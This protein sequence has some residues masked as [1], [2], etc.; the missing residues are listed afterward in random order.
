[1]HSLFTIGLTLV[2]KIGFPKEINIKHY[3]MKTKLILTALVGAL[4]FG[5]SQQSKLTQTEA[6]EIAKE[7]YVYGFPMVM[8]YKTLYAYVLDKNSPE[9]K[10]EFNE[11]SCDARLFTPENKA[12]VTPNSDT[13]YCMFWCDIRTEPVVFSVP[14]IESERYYS[15]QLIDMY[16]HNFA[17]IGSL[18]SG[19]SAGKYLIAPNSWKGEK[20]EGITNIIPCETGLFFTVVRTQLMNAGDIDKVKEIQGEYTI[21]T[22]SDYLDEE[23]KGSKQ[24][25]NFPDWVEGDQFTA[26]AFNFL[27]VVLKH[28]D[29]VEEEKTLM[30]KFA[31]IGLRTKEGFDINK[32]DQETQDSIQAGVKEGFAEMEEFIKKYAADPLISAKIFGTREFLVQSAQGNYNLENMHIPRAVAAH[33]G[34]YGNSGFEATYPTYLA[35]AEAQ[36]LNASENS[37]SITFNTDELPPVKAFWSITMYDGKT[38]LLINN[39]IDRYLVNSSMI[40]DFV[41]GDDGSLT[42]Y[43]QKESPGKELEA[44][45]LPAPDG[46]FYCVMRLYGPE[47]SALSGEW[48]NPPIVKNNK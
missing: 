37:Y 43:V 9:Y 45:W 29:P 15:F 13:P 6:K 46:P 39:P 8:N 40:D 21:Q 30:Q 11:M 35:D 34:L 42:I 2:G 36:P 17:Y 32:F 31:K 25:E 38:Q 5:F 4:F 23:P 16:T 22:L 14:E 24:K 44:N 3:K 27:D 28:M 10:G 47:E 12:V 48:V 26:N 7:A 18:T 19:S 20:P 1:M 33:M 41:F